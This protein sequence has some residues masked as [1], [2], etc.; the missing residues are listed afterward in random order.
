MSW[1]DLRKEAGDR[2]CTFP[3]ESAVLLLVRPCFSSGCPCAASFSCASSS[4][5]CSRSMF[6]FGSSGGGESWRSEGRSGRSSASDEGS[7]CDDGF[8]TATIGGA[9]GEEL[10]AAGAA[11]PAM[12]DSLLRGWKSLVSAISV[13]VVSERRRR[14]GAVGDSGEGDVWQGSS[15]AA[16]VARAEGDI[17][18]EPRESFEGERGRAPSR[19]LSRDMGE[20]RGEEAMCMLIPVSNSWPPL[21]AWKVCGKSASE[22]RDFVRPHCDRRSELLLRIIVQENLERTSS[23]HRGWTMCAPFALAD[24]NSL[25][26]SLAFEPAQTRWVTA[27]LYWR[28][29]VPPRS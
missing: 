26:G 14:R 22:T 21:R 27:S 9:G 2:G 20:P 10:M 15:A 23:I 18:G 13:A 28:A 17:R 3:R 7:G 6:L 29:A 16:S 1:L 11:D 24:L 5:V 12:G 8:C 19:E 4:D 25:Y